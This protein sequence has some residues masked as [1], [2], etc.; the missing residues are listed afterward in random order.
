VADPPAHTMKIRNRLGTV[1]LVVL[2]V[3][4]LLVLRPVALG[5]PASYEIV[6]GTS[7]E[8]RLHTG[9]LVITQT[10]AAYAIGEIVVY[11]VPVG[12]PGAGSIIVHRIVGEVAGGFSIQGD[13]KTEPDPWLV[14]ATDI[15]GR[16]WV[17]IPNVGEALL[18]AR[19]P[20]VLATLIGGL[21]FLLLLSWKPKPRVKVA[22]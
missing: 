4:W 17:D 5:G 10:A 19:R 8:P 3:V 12:L 22:A 9:D 16:R 18:V 7:M 11:R 14:N 2:A 20:L 15:I 1:A 21:G 6:T 13:N